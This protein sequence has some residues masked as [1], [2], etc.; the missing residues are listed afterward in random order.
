MIDLLTDE[1][2]VAIETIIKNLLTAS[3]PDYVTLTPEE[4]ENLETALNSSDKISLD[5]FKKEL[6]M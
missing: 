4:R 3:D 5:E 2:R 1:S 6:G